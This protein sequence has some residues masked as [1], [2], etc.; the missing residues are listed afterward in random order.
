M[1]HILLPTD[2][3]A[4]SIK[5]AFFALDHFG[6]GDNRYT[7]L[8]VYL[9][10][11][12][13]NA[14]LPVGMNTEKVAENGLRRVER[15]CRQHAGK[16]HIAKRTSFDVLVNAV[17]K[18]HAKQPVDMVVMGTQGEGNFG[19]VGHHTGLL[20]ANALPPV[21]AVPDQWEPARI[22]RILL[23]DDGMGMS[24]ETL[25]PLV[26]IA[27]RTKAH[28]EVVHVH[29][30]AKKRKTAER[31]AMLFPFLS[32][33]PHSFTSLSDSDVTRAIDRLALERKVQLVAV[34]RRKR[35]FWD[36][37]VTGSTTKEMALHTTVP[38]L[39]LREVV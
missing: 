15:Q 5:A 17:N 4:T 19:R 36:R 14:L 13:R 28:V 34:V 21:I 16:V 27:K 7:L 2:F 31:S 9:K 38:L 12:Y 8:N 22:E 11:A 1:K 25:R 3:S 20:V 29:A 35:S 32:G 24:N 23:A 10:T 6:T 26:D 33:V 37:I 18:L 30:D 39:V